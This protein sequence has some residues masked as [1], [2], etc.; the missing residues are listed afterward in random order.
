MKKIFSLL[1]LL[2]LCTLAC[3]QP[4]AKYQFLEDEAEPQFNLSFNA[5]TATTGSL[6]LVF[7]Y[8]DAANYYALDLAPAASGAQSATLKSVLNGVEHKL[9][10]SA[11]KIPSGTSITLQRRPWLMRVLVGKTALLTAYDATLNEGRI[12]FANSGRWSY[13]EPRVQPVEESIFFND[14]FT[15]DRGETGEWKIASGQWQIT[16]ASDRITTG[17][18]DMSANPFSFTVKPGSTPALAQSGRRFWDNYDAQ[19]SVLPAAQ[20]TI[21]VA[22]YVQDASNYLALLWSS[23]EGPEARRLV[24]V[25][26]GQSTLLAKAPGA[27]LPR[28]WYRVSMRTSPGFVEATIDGQPALR[29]RS[30]AFAQ[31]GVGLIAQ[32]TAANF[33]DVHVRSYPYF[34]QD[35]AGPTG[36]AW[37]PAGGFWRADAGTLNSASKPGDGGATRTLVA[38]DGSWGNYQITASGKTGENGACGLMAG[39][40]DDKNFLVFRWAGD[41]STL[42]FKGR[43]QLLRYKDGKAEILT[44]STAPEPENDGYVRAT[45][46]FV[47]G[48]ATVLCK[49]QILAQAADESLQSGQPGLWAQGAPTVSF[50]EVVMF[51][52][53]EPD[54]PKVAP[55]FEGDSLMVGWASPSGEWPPRRVENNLEFWN[56][57]EFFGDATVEYV[58]R[59]TLYADGVY[60]VSLHAKDG[61]FKSG[62][63]VRVEG[64]DT[65]KFS[66]QSGAQTVKTAEVSLK[67]LNATDAKPPQIRIEREGRAVLVSANAT[68]LL[69]YLPGDGESTPTGTKIAARSQ[70]F[71]IQA[72]DLRAM[73]ANRD[74]YTFSEAPTD[75]YSPQGNWTVFHRW[76]CYSDWSF[77]GGTGTAPIIWSKREYSGDTVVEFYSHP[78]MNLPKELGYAHP[79][80]LNVT[81][82]GDG[83]SLASGYSFVLAGWFNT[84]TAIMK[85]NTVVAQTDSKPNA[86]FE[87]AIN[88]NSQ[89]HRKWFYIR[90]E[91]RRETQDGKAGVRLKFFVDNELMCEYFDPAPLNSFENGGRIAFWTVGGAMMIARAKIES[92]RPGARALPGG[93]LDAFDQEDSAASG[94]G[95]WPQPV[96]MDGLPSSRVERS[97]DA[98]KI[99]NPLSGGLFAV[100][101]KRGSESTLRATPTTKLEFDAQLPADVKVDAYVT[102]GDQRHLIEISGDQRLD[103]RAPKLGAASVTT[104][105]GNGASWKHVSFDLGDALQKMYPKASSWSVQKIELGALHGDE[106]RWAG[107]Y[108]NNIGSS[109]QIKN[110]RL[111]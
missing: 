9:D 47:G 106:Y 103:A 1:L 98:W 65:L 54:A 79:G 23:Q 12:G 69:S 94:E 19:V 6:S 53:P 44:D 111:D 45:L 56:T 87:R 88:H 42:P 110:V 81:L 11:T 50:R 108:G 39:Y 25:E 75:W 100:Q 48:A 80:D 51:L 8:K 62:T 68:P 101:L 66:I 71:T 17:N 61:D 38:G 43:A 20:G 70:K 107:F 84:K 18:Q 89:F 46:R 52:P 10:S 3:A 85:G 97:G 36:G 55:R 26:N 2:S 37:T 49:G 109:Y 93:L 22:V 96:K 28:Q 31:G 35:F 60:E 76:P 33:D 105:A 95:F 58:W 14:D 30:D 91:S 74:D 21:G 7:D 13:T 92:E 104:V 29:A 34:R 63:V 15:R 82:G 73:S 32:K 40:R 90:A 67:Q 16:A 77:F 59:P 72:K 5:T 102:I 86:T 78:Q 57:G 83:K 99:T 27:Y 41:K 4:A 64:K 24:K